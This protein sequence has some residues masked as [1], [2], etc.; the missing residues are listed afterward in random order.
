MRMRSLLMLWSLHTGYMTEYPRLSLNHPDT[1]SYSLDPIIKNSLED[2]D[3][4]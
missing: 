2:R 3:G 1:V 4:H